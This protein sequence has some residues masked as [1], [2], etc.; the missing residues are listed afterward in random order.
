[1]ISLMKASE[2]SGTLA[3]MLGR[4]GDYLAKERRTAKQIKGALR[5]PI[6][7]VTV[8]ML[9]TIFL[10][11]FVLPRF[12]LI[13]EAK[14][15]TLPLPTSVLLAISGFLTT[16]YMWYGPALIGVGFVGLVW[17]RRP[18]G[19]AM[20][21]WMRLNLPLVK[22]MYTHLYLTRA[23]RTMATLLSAGV[24]ILDVIDICRG[25]TGNVYYSELWG[26][27]ADG[28]R[29]GRQVSDAVTSSDLI[30]PNIASMIAAGERSGQLPEVMEKIADFTQEELDGAVKQV[31]AFIEPA[32][33][34]FLGG[35]IGTCAL[36]MLL[37]MFNMS[38]LFLGGRGG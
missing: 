31:T 25:V 24:S 9:V 20:M 18:S 26:E 7:V 4:V 16:Q 11:T 1:M 2:A 29:E 8:A 32:M 13:Y 21:D 33:I 35:V 37:P 19:R 12:A 23:A 5:Y 27:M 28:V 6:F 34:I 14:S 22:G 36:A 10:M 3:T 15:A 17:F 38:R 30:P